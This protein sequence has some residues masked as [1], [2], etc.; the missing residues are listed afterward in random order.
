MTPKEIVEAFGIDIDP[1]PPWEGE[2]REVQASI[3]GY[4]IRLIEISENHVAA[5]ATVMDGNGLTFRANIKS[6][7]D[8]TFVY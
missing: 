5:Q 2:I 7:D 8:F 1:Q 6:V 3:R 4:R